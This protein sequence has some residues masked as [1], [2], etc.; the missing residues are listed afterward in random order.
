MNLSFRRLVCGAALALAATTGLVE[1]S[2]SPASGAGFPSAPG[3]CVDPLAMPDWC[4][5]IPPNGPLPPA[6]NFTTRQLKP[7]I[8]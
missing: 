2:V 4:Q 3:P 5:G 8:W 7:V 6:L 1:A